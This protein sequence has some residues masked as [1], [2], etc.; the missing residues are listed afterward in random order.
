MRKMFLSLIF[1][2]FA[3]N[4]TFGQEQA[5][6]NLPEDFPEITI[7]ISI[8]PSPGV[9]Y[10]ANLRRQGSE[11]RSISHYLMVLDNEG[12]PTFYQ[13]VERS[14]NFGRTNDGFRYYYDFTDNGLGRGSAT[15][16]IYNILDISGEIV[17]EYS[18]Q[19]DLPTQAHE[20]VQLENGNV[21]LLSQPVRIRDLSE[22]GGDPEA[23]VVEAVIQ[24]LDEDNNIVFEWRSWEHVELT[25]TTRIEEL[26]Y[27]PPEPVSYLHANALAVDLDGNIIL[28]ARRFDELI[29]IDRETGDI[30]WRMGGL[31][32][33]N[34]EFTFIDDP[35]FGFSGQ[36]NIQ[37]LENGN[38]L[39]FDN[40]SLHEE[41]LSRAVEY[42]I[43]EEKSTATLVWSYDDGRFAGSM[44]SVQ[45]LANGNTLI[46]WGSAPATGPSVSEVTAD[47]EVVFALSLPESQMSY[48]AYRF[49]E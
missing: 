33:K 7:D 44:G 22:Y 13:K 18:V 25:D 47:G 28:S 27:E 23:L 6:S 38:Y 41:R 3:I 9:I 5:A 24:E 26:Q 2:L 19:A 11:N 17:Q 42:R 46:G 49:D 34:N 8:D 1:L 43:D 14:F 12:V 31:R 35:N 32:S 45:R 15:D 29:K 37:V 30:I 4:I 10:L 16:G 20:F 40:G 21:L 39:L 48:R 36:H